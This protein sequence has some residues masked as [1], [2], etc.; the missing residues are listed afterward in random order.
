MQEDDFWTRLECRL[1]QEM[2]QLDECRALGMWCDGL[3]P[4][5]YALRG[6][7]RHIQG[8]CWIG[9]GPRN[10]ETWQFR[11]VLKDHL[12]KRSEIYW[13][14]F[15]PPDGVTGWLR[16]FPKQRFLEIAPR[17]GRHVS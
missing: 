17:A 2:G 5:Q 15:L 11:L 9:L 3:R 13:P 14:Y 8:E 6:P 4:E 12:S 10:Q 16:V 7:G 1:T